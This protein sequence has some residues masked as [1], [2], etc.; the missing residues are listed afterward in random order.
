[1]GFPNGNFPQQPQIQMPTPNF[2]FLQGHATAQQQQPFQNQQFFGN[3]K[4]NNIH[5]NYSA[6][7]VFNNQQQQQQIPQQQIKN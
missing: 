2:S 6:I 7:P 3:P 1:M 5:Y 4:P